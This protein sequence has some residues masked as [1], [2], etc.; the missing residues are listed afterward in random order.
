M[1]YKQTSLTVDRLHK[2]SAISCRGL[3]RPLVNTVQQSYPSLCTLQY[4]LDKKAVLS[5][6]W[7]RNAPYA[8]VPWKFLGLPDYAHGY[9]SQHFSW[10]FVPIDPMNV[11]TKF[12]VRSFTRSWDNSRGTQKIWL[13]PVYAHAPFSPKFFMRFYSDWPC[14]CTC[15]IWSP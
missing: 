12:E 8:W 7:L 9:Y 1:K 2:G 11:A 5:Q 10:A 14:K 13:V 4:K 6:R 15:Q 3:P